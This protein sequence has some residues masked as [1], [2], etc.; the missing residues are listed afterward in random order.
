M[1]EE[2]L[3]NL[4]MVRTYYS[5]LS[6]LLTIFFSGDMLV[7]HDEINRNYLRICAK[8]SETLEKP[9]C[10]QL[11]AHG[12]NSDSLFKSTQFFLFPRKNWIS[13]DSFLAL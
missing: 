9:G 3:R 4:F 1:K 7:F 6:S 8:I 10:E 2:S 12:N 11:K 5:E 13:N